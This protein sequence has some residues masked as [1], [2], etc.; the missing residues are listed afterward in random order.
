MKSML[1]SII[2]NFSTYT[3]LLAVRI[4]SPDISIERNVLFKGDVRNIK[5][6]K[7]VVIQSGSVL[8]GG[9][10]AWCENKGSIVIGDNSTISPNCVLYGCGKGGIKI[11]KNFDCG[12]FAGIYAS[13]T[14]YENKEKHIFE[15]VNIGDNVVV[16]SH[17][18]IS[19]GVSIGDGAVIAAGSIVI[20]DVPSNTL[21]AGTPA[22]VIKTLN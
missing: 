10:K 21:A 18:T 17:V 22:K 7:S 6:G 19:P 16:F 8:H 1:Y 13:R 20:S 12:P 14:D 5:I 15:P 9:G 2:E 11:G 4:K 3:R